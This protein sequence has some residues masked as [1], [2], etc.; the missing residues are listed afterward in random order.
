VAE[1]KYGK[2]I[3]NHPIVNLPHPIEPGKIWQSLDFVG[4]RD[5]GSDFS[6]VLLPVI[7]PVLMEA[8]PPHWHEFDMYLTLIGFDPRGLEDLGAEVEMS[9][10]EEQEKHVITTPSTIY[11]PKGLVHCPFEFKRVDKPLLLIHATLAAKYIKKGRK[12]GEN[13]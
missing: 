13:G 8:G 11:I 10:G 4:E 1:T 7:E 12:D 9:F 2:L 3:R 5:F 6:L